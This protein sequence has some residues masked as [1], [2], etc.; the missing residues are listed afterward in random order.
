M[1]DKLQNGLRSVLQTMALVALVVTVLSLTGSAVYAIGYTSWR[2]PS[3]CGTVASQCAD[4]TGDGTG[5]AAT[6]TDTGWTG[7]KCKKGADNM[8]CICGG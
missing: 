6:T 2:T 5:C 7:T 1:T 3:G 4:T 8:H